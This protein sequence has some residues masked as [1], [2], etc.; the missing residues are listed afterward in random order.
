[1]LGLDYDYFALP[2]VHTYGG[3]LV[4]WHKDTWEVSQPRLGTRSLT[5]KVTLRAAASQPWW[6]M[7]VYGPQGDQDKVAFL[8]ELR[9]RRATLVGPWLLRGD[10]NLIY[11]AADKKK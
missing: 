4:A 11:Q 6:L 7:S 2:T 10:F 9:S 5:V 3:I 1:M 8:Q